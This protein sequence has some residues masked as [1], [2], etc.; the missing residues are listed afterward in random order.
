MNPVRQSF[1]RA[2]SSYDNVGTLQQQVAT[3]LT[4]LV[5]EKLPASFSGRLI[6]AGCGTGYCLK[7]LSERYPTAE[8]VAVDFAERM[9]QQ[10]PLAQRTLGMTADLQQLP[11][12]DNGIDVY[13]SS[14][15]WQWCDP[16]RAAHEAKRVLK[17]Q[18]AFFITTLAAGTFEELAQCL[19]ISGLNPD[20]HLLH[21]LSRED[22]QSAIAAAGFEAL[23]LSTTRITTWHPDF[24]SLRHTIRGVGANHPP[25]QTTPVLNRQTRTRLINAYEQLRTERGLPLSYDVLTIHARKR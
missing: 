18:G 21:C 23:N 11:I 14:L 1:N 9:L 20:Q 25:S 12:A 10:L 5:T 19:Q 3:S 2:A 22:V 8:L 7:A 17:P 16:A 6:D 4:E 24:R 13:L 15:A